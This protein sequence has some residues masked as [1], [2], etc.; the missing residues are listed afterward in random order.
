MTN[1]TEEKIW[2]HFSTNKVRRRIKVINWT[3]QIFKRWGKCQQ[4][5]NFYPESFG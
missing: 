5:K 4:L 1:K 2:G 3:T